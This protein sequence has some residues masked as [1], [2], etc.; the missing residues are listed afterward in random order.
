MHANH[1]ERTLILDVD[2]K[3]V[4]EASDLQSSTTASLLVRPA[5]CLDFKTNEPDENTAAEDVNS[6]NRLTRRHRRQGHVHGLDKAHILSE[7]DDETLYEVVGKYILL[8]EALLVSFQLLWIQNLLVRVQIMQ[9]RFAQVTLHLHL[10][11]FVLQPHALLMPHAITLTH[12]H[13]FQ[14]Y[15][16]G[17]VP[18]DGAMRHATGGAIYFN[19]HHQQG[20]Q[21]EPRQK[22]QHEHNNRHSRR[23]RAVVEHGP[24]DIL[25]MRVVYN[26]E[27]PS[28]V[29]QA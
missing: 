26:G 21:M 10:D 27:D 15:N 6:F 5:A 20:Q 22:G 14:L 11:P 3:A 29:A 18:V 7:E 24:R 1:S 8:P 2:P 9:M 19:P 12:V 25:I 16:E 28:Y 23:K 17:T 4:L 13:T